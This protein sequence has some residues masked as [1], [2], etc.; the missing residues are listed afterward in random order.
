[1]HSDPGGEGVT[2]VWGSAPRPM[3]ACGF[4]SGVRFTDL[5]RVSDWSDSLLRTG[6]RRDFSRYLDR[7]W[8]TECPG[9]M[10][11]FWRARVKVA[12]L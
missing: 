6:W 8:E 7:G 1:M 4:M 2:A 10:Q 3:P 5:Q 12:S 9:R 11:D